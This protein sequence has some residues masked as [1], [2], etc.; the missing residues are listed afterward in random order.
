M[1]YVYLVL[2]ELLA[3]SR[4]ECLFHE[5]L[6]I[7]MTNAWNKLKNAHFNAVIHLKHIK[8]LRKYSDCLAYTVGLR[9]NHRNVIIYLAYGLGYFKSFFEIIR[10]KIYLLYVL[11][12]CSV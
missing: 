1:L 5:E 9:F 12:Q 7:K 8:Y 10:A 2:I 11:N 6:E 3:Y 4:A